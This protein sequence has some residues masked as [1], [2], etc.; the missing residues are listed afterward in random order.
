MAGPSTVAAPNFVIGGHACIISA[1]FPPGKSCGV[2]FNHM[3]RIG[4]VFLIIGALFGVG[5]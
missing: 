4:C 3:F 2:P 5:Q 1:K